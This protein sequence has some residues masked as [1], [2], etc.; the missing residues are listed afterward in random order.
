ME[1]LILLSGQGPQGEVLKLMKDDLFRVL[2]A[3]WDIFFKYLARLR[4]GLYYN[5]MKR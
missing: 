1:W 4:N 2:L 5:C 3:V